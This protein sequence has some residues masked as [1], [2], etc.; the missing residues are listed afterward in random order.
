[1]QPQS[2]ETKDRNPS[3]ATMH[4]TKHLHPTT[5]SLQKQNYPRRNLFS[6]S[7]ISTK[8]TGGKIEK[9]G[10][11]EGGNRAKRK[12]HKNPSSHLLFK[13][14]NPTK[15]PPTDATFS[16]GPRAR[17]VTRSPPEETNARS[18]CFGRSPTTPRDHTP[19]ALTAKPL[20]PIAIASKQMP[21]T[22]HS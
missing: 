12:L 22:I 21:T 15:K 4:P 2:K 9:G 13:T 18:S 17:P 11:I 1:M 10:S 7:I 14:K 3:K 8:Q 16:G 5:T 6:C 19:L 20:K